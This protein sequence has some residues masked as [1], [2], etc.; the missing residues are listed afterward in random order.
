MEKKKY[1]VFIVDD[2]PEVCKAVELTL[3][4]Q[5]YHVR[6]FT[7]ANMCFKALASEQCDVLISDVNMPE[8]N[9]IEFLVKVKSQ[10]PWLPLLVITGY[11]SVPR[12]VHAIKVGAADF[13]EKPFEREMFLAKVK[14]ALEQSVRYR[15]EQNSNLTKTESRILELI[16]AGRCNK[17]IA[18]LLHRSV[19]TVEDHRAHIMQK[20]DAKNIVELVKQVLPTA[21]LISRS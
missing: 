17:E 5:K 16:V 15:L 4:R 10:Y 19:R 21:N 14:A 18:R 3:Q 8:I 1:C 13:I 11:G 20:L 12:A 2:E 6:T 7:S 9:G